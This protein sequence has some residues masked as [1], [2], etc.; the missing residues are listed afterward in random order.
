M[1]T[2][3]RIE[4]K[5]RL[6][7]VSYINDINL[8]FYHNLF[9]LKTIVLDLDNTLARLDC[10]FLHQK[11]E[12]WFLQNAELFEK[13]RINLIIW[14]NMI[15]LTHRRLDRAN[16]IIAQIKRIL[17]KNDIRLLPLRYLNRKP[18]A[19]SFLDLLMIYDCDF[20]HPSAFRNAL[21]IGDQLTDLQVA[22]QNDYPV[23]YL[24]EKLGK[25]SIFTTLFKRPKEK[26][27]LKLL[28]Y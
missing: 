26:T 27:A 18:T 16:K 14:T 3:S 6:S 17:P 15:F 23:I 24:K 2:L 12:E 11:S 5:K 1:P 20:A 13:N 9:Q 21:F 22:M 8:D 25:D 28:G 19:L 7:V 4:T 10:D